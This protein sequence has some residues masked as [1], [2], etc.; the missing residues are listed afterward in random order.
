MGVLNYI[1]WNVDPV[2][3]TIGP[4]QLRY[5]GLLFATGFLIGYYIMQYVFNKEKIPEKEL[6]NLSI[7]VI[8]GAVIG[9]RLGHVLFYQP[10][11]YFKNPLEI[12]MI[13]HGGLASHG[14]ALGVLIAVWIYTKKSKRSYLWALDRVAIPT[15]LAGSLIRLG[16]LMNSEIIGKP[17]NLPW[18]FRFIRY[19]DP[20]QPIDNFVPRH[21]AQLYESICYLVIFIILFYIYK[22]YKEKSPKGLLLGIFLISVFGM[23][24]LIEFI[25]EN[26][27]PFE[28]NM[29]I[30]MGQILSIPFI[31]VGIWLLINVSRKKAKTHGV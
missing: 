13:W 10:D 16:N 19:Y 6:N 21:P 25:K 8:L 18:G 7:S 2:I 15:A 3:F 22:K 30:N 14:G 23:R 4:L 11:Y 31:I 28:S 1:T 17:T 9:A 27:V 29:S 24:F 20:E 26:Q 5:Y 12:L